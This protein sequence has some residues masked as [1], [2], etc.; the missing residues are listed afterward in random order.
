MNTTYNRADL[1]DNLLC[2]IRSRCPGRANAVKASVFADIFR[3]SVR[4]INEA[5]R[6]LRL[7]GILIGSSK[8]KPFGYYIPQSE[9]E[10]RNYFDTYRAE[11]F[12]MLYIYNRQKRASKKHLEALHDQ[13]RFDF[14]R[15]PTG[16][17][18]LSL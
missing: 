12:D 18:V 3:V 11:L 8:E 1:K 2:S 16:Q 5:V 4:D 10:V 13:K 17:L 6:Q 14:D 15:E 7:A 9:E